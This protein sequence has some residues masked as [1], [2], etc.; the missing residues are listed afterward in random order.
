[1]KVKVK[2]SAEEMRV[3]YK[4]MCSMVV[5]RKGLSG[6]AAFDVVT[7]FM[8]KLQKRMLNLKDKQT[9]SLTSVE[10]YFLFRK[11]QNI[12]PGQQIYEATLLTKIVNHIFQQ[13]C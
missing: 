13:T 7:A 6:F 10:A 4:I 9:L 8:F 12:L 3:L 1:M 2:L 5:I 11:F